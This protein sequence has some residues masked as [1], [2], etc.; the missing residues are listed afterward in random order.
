MAITESSYYCKT[1]KLFCVLGDFYASGMQDTEVTK[2]LQMD[3]E[4]TLFWG[5]IASKQKTKHR[6]LAFSCDLSRV[7]TECSDIFAVGVY[8]V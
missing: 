8:N 5:S 4:A 3:G 1:H 7:P 6:S 2:S